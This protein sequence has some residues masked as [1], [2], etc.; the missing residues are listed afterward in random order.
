VIF[1]FSL[2]KLLII[3]VMS[4]TLLHA[5]YLPQVV[6]T[7]PTFYTCCPPPFQI[8][9]LISL[10]MCMIWGRIFDMWSFF[11]KNVLILYTQFARNIRT[12]PSPTS[13]PP[14]LPWITMVDV[15]Q[16]CSNHIGARSPTF[17]SIFEFIF[18]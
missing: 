6:P 16:T 2:I 11:F 18:K 12:M 10:I 3:C 9:V 4:P 15:K 1:R 5:C 14:H 17:P 8:R 7:T 13:Q